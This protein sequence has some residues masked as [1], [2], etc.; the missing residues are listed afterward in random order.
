MISNTTIKPDRIY[1]WRGVI[2]H[3]V[4]IHVA[5]KLPIDQGKTIKFPC[6]FPDLW[7]LILRYIFNKFWFQQLLANN[8][9]LPSLTKRK[10][11]DSFPS[12]Q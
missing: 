11:F 4:T 5:N 3:I 9:F 12:L 6:G 7:F 2:L 10:W 8:C 1:H